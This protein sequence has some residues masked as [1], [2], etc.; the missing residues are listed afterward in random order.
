[1][2]VEVQRVDMPAKRLEV[3]RFTPETLAIATSGR[4]SFVCGWKKRPRI[5]RSTHILIEANFG[6][7]YKVIGDGWAKTAPRDNDNRFGDDFPFTVRLDGVRIISDPENF[8]ASPLS[9][10]AR[11]VSM[12]QDGETFINASRVVVEL[13][14]L[15]SEGFTDDI[16]VIK[17]W[18]L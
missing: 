18:D 4:K 15:W 1:M 13:D 16:S 2:S 11:A 10:P 9:W 12:E 7:A 8:I 6:D 14:Y 17:S 3:A 5:D